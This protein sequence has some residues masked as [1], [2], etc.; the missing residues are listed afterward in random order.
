MSCEVLHF[1]HQ[2]CG[3]TPIL[4]DS[5]SITDVSQQDLKAPS[6]SLCHFFMYYTLLLHTFIFVHEHVLDK[7][8]DCRRF[9]RDGIKD[10]GQCKMG[11][12]AEIGGANRHRVFLNSSL[13]AACN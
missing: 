8:C 11:L 1:D 4:A 5:I 9:V 6:H 13:R 10:H 3:N 2:Q 7:V 12:V